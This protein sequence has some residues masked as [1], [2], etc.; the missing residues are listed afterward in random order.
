MSLTFHAECEPGDDLLRLVTA[1]APANPFCTPAYV[2]ARQAQGKPV[3]VLGL[4]QG[5]ELTW[6][7]PALL[8]AGRWSRS[9]EIESLPWDPD[10]LFWEGLTRFCRARRVGFLEVW[11]MATPRATLPALSGEEWRRP[12]FEHVIRLQNGDLWEA[13]ATN[14]KRNVKRARKAGVALRVTSDPAACADHARLM[15]L[16]MGRRKQ[17]GESV[18]EDIKAEHHEP[19][20]RSGAGQLFQVVRGGEVLSSVLV[21]TAE[22][23]AYYQ[24]AGTSP[25]GMA[26]GASPFLI[27]EIA[28]HLQERRMEVFNLG[29]AAPENPG[30]FR[31]KGELGAEAV[32]LECAGYCTGSRLWRSLKNAGRALR[33]RVGGLFCGERL[34]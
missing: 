2:R 24:T 21:L 33:E 18:A 31:F 4:R 5:E 13:L 19:Y 17:R 3:W 11:T 25:E 15:A 26:C 12:R 32:P 7:C 30:L 16:S 10:P 23:G 14:Q 6:A 27:H 1:L 20:L 9:L 34:A 29:G 22:R 8:H 28:R